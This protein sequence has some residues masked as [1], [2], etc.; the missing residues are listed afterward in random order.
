MGEDEIWFGMDCGN[1]NNVFKVTKENAWFY[2]SESVL[3]R[4]LSIVRGT[5]SQVSDA[6]QF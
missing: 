1:I 3:D 2:K 4:K 5:V 6:G